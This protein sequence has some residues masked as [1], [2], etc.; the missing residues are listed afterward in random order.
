MANIFTKLQVKVSQTKVT[1]TEG[2]K[3]SKSFIPS[4][5]KIYN[6][7][8][9]NLDSARQLCFSTDPADTANVKNHIKQKY[10]AEYPHSIAICS[11]A[12][13]FLQELIMIIH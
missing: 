5:H 2:L 7:I 6:F 11:S 10:S 12:T 13:D 9:Q 8:L 3:G 4:Y 1:I